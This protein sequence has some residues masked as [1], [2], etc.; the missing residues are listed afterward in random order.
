MINILIVCFKINYKQSTNGDI[1]D[2]VH[3]RDQPAFDHPLLKNHEIKSVLKVT[4]K[5]S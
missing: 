5:S 2:C 3:M 1:I 4:P